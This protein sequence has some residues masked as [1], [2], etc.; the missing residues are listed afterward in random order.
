ML[1]Q[2]IVCVVIGITFFWYDCDAAAISSTN[3]SWYE[4]F[5]N[6]ARPLNVCTQPT[7]F[8]SEVYL[9]ND[10]KELL[11]YSYKSSTDCSGDPDSATISPR[12]HHCGDVCP[13]MTWK[14]C[15]N[16]AG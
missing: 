10:K 1:P 4:D 3:C 6:A 9:C 2:A 7:E 15:A 11:R 5:G 13:Y 8:T 12:D 14:H 16:Y